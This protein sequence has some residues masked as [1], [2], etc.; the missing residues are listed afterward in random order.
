METLFKDLPADR[1][2]KKDFT[3]YAKILL[4]KNQGYSKMV[5]DTAKL[6]RDLKRNIDR[7]AD[8]KKPETKAK[9]QTQIDTL[10]IKIANI[11]DQIA[12]ADVEINKAFV[13]YEKAIAITPDDKSLLNEVAIN[14][15]NYKR[16]IESAK[17]FEKLA[18][19]GKNDVADLM[20]IGRAYNQ[21]R[22]YMKA[23]SI[24]NLVLQKDPNYIPAYVA[25][26]NAYA[27]LDPDTKEGLAKPKFEMVIQKARIDTVKYSNELFDA[28][29]YMGYYNLT[30]KNFSKSKDYY[31]LM[32][33]LNPDNKDFKV[34]GYNALGYMYYSQGEYNKAIETY[35]KTLE[36]DSGNET[37]KTSIKNAQTNIDNA[38]NAQF[39]G[40]HYGTVVDA[41]GQPIANAS[42]RVKDTAA[43][44]WTGSKGEFAFEIPKGS[45]AFVVSAKGYKNKEVIIVAKVFKYNITLEQ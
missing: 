20:Q 36:V 12:S 23:D 16:F 6:N 7:L 43:E 17:T 26:A 24:F 30:N 27:A 15:Y 22:S 28:Y 29:R 2:I 32:I 8:A 44:V 40:K 10:N 19:L 42:V 13:A 31:E 14:Y 45:E 39:K 33:K 25:I 11:T 21:G 35:N 4:K 1:L 34:R 3:Y 41:S 9:Y 38:F 18:V 5:Q 37:A